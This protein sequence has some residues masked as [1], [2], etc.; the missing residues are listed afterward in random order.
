MIVA[1]TMARDEADVIA[2][3]VR[4]LYLQ[5]IDHVIVADNLST[6]GTGDLA[7]DAGAEVTIDDDPRYLQ[8]DK[9]TVLARRAAELGATWVLPF[10]ADELWYW[11]EGTL[12]EFFDQCSATVVEA[13]CWDHVATGDID[14]HPYAAI[15]HRRTFPQ[16]FP[17]VAFRAHPD[18]R[19]EQGNHNVQRVGP[20]T[21]GLH[22]RHFQ[23]RTFEQTR[24]KIT[25]G[26]AAV[27]AAGLPAYS[28]AHWRALA[29]LSESD[30][31]KWWDQLCAEPGLL[32]D[33]APWSR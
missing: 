8:A 19:L 14:S 25:Q 26:A 5:G 23:Y 16:T 3:T 13:K 31:R 30:L 24:R 7:R 20:R 9:M 27:D 18:A 1:V 12:G 10:D 2:E 32:E 22:L 11:P 4:H 21:G 33:P 15:T 6:D 17:K 29:G 28:G